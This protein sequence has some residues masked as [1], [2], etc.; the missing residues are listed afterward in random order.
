MKAWLGP[1]EYNEFF[2]Y[3]YRDTMVAALFLNDRAGMHV[4]KIPYP[5]VNL[6]YLAS[7]EKIPYDRKHDALADCMVTA[8]VYKRMVSSGLLA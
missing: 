6:R 1:D 2:D 3:H 8:Q 5:K 7:Q 4:D